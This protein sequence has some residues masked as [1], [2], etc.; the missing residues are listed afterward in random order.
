MIEMRYEDV[1]SAIE[2]IAPDVGLDKLEGEPHL[3]L[4]F[5][6]SH[7][8]QLHE[9]RSPRYEELLTWT[10]LRMEELAGGGQLEVG[11][12]IAS[13]FDNLHLLADDC[14]RVV[15]ILGPKCQELR[16]IYERAT[17]PLCPTTQKQQ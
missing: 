6:M 1:V 16:Q 5:L 4:G 13:F 7:L 15:A 9:S 12:V 11:L 8:G 17:G 10:A 3:V 14:E 2:S